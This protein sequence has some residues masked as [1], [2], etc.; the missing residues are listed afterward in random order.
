MA[1]EMF[2]ALGAGLLR[3]GNDLWNGQM[4][5]DDRD[6][7]DKVR[8]EN[9]QS[10]L[11]MML[12]KSKLAIQEAR[13]RME[14][15]GAY[16]RQQGAEVMNEG[17]RIASARQG[18][19]LDAGEA[20]IRQHVAP[21]DQERLTGMINQQRANPTPTSED[22]MTAE[23]KMGT[24]RAS[25]LAKFKEGQEKESYDRNRQANLDE[26]NVR[27]RKFMENIQSKQLSVSLAASRDAALDRAE[28]R[29]DKKAM[30]TAY[31]KLMSDIATASSS[32][33]PSKYMSQISQS[34]LDIR[35]H[36][37][38]DLTDSVFGKVK[39]T[40]KV[41]D[42]VDMPDGSERKIERDT[43]ARVDGMVRTNGSSKP[44]TGG[45]PWEK[46]W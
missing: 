10:E 32:D 33:D 3:V 37:G 27:H 15:E 8:A 2:S 23:V 31:D 5:Q 9:R 30:Q 11:A 6:Y 19:Q 20:A 7:Q 1:G 24:G 45:K 36:G 17:M 16:K 43:S 44:V 39:S 29:E 28:K 14:M 25:D 35:K 40:G 41:I 34:I 13:Q 26:E 38:P 22:L 12:E 42:K 18:P 4:K 46:K 21:Q